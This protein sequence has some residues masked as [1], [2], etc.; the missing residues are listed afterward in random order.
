M[1]ELAE[2][3]QLGFNTNLNPGGYFLRFIKPKTGK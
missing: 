3:Y 1:P 2:K